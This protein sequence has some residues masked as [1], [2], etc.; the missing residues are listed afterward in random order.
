MG[1]TRKTGDS[2]TGGNTLVTVSLGDSEDINELVLGEDRVDGDLLFEERL[3]KVNLGLSI[4][5]SVNLNLHDVSLTDTKVELL[6]LRVGDDT[7]NLT[8]L[9]DT[10][11]LLL[12]IFSIV[13]SVLLGV[14]GVSLTLALVPVLV[15]TTLEFLT[16]V[17][18]EDGGQGTKST[19]SLQVSN[20]TDDN[21]G[22]GLQDG[23]GI[24]NL[25]FVHDGS[26]T[27][28]TTDDVGHTGLVGTEGSKV[29]GS[30]CI[31]VPGEGTDASRV[32]LGT[33]LWEESQ[34]SVTGSFEFTVGHG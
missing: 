6:H 1:L 16:Q 5:T 26:G 31:I 22:R 30:G 17:L 12:D 2:P 13:L 28:N 20:N 18:S 21:H 7:D 24:N 19:R 25:T 10:L 3:G 33:L 23:N 27:V 9:G 34:V 8:V 15:R 32:V 11:K 29:W 14:L 4:G